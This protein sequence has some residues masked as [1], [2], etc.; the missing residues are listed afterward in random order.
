MCEPSH[1]KTNSVTS[2]LGIDPDQPV[3]SAQVNPDRHIPY[4][5]DR[6]VMSPETE[7]QQEANSVYPV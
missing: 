5:G 1:E 7:N 2:A 3:Q 6:G 4:Q